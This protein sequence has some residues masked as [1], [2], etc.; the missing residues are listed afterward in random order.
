[1]AQDSYFQDLCIKAY[2]KSSDSKKCFVFFHGFPGEGV[3]NEDLAEAISKHTDAT[4]FVIHFGGLGNGRGEFG[5]RRSVE[6]SIACVDSIVA[7]DK[8]E[9]FSLYGHSW[10]GLVAINV[11][12]K[13]ESKIDK[14]ILASPYCVLPP[15]AMVR[16]ILAGYVAESPALAHVFSIEEGVD[17]LDFIDQHFNPKKALLQIELKPGSTLF[18]QAKDDDEVP[19]AV[20]RAFLPNFPVTPEYH[21][22]D[23]VH[24]FKKRA[25]L[26]STLTNW[27][28]SR[29][30]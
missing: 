6:Q 2:S 19:T 14:L 4:C 28:N 12:S 1:M 27:L 11:A 25:D 5:F 24:S 22:V 23:Q 10:G 9:S 8:F 16:K 20:S 17:D 7:S 18:L 3:R 26:I 29:C 13:I 30:R 21:E 15:K